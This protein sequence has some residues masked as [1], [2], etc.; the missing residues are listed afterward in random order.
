MASALRMR[1]TKRREVPDD[2]RQATRRRRCSRYFFRMATAGQDYRWGGEFGP[3][4]EALD[5]VRASGA[6]SATQG[7]ISREFA[8]ASRDDYQLVLRDCGALRG[9]A[10]LSDH[11]ELVAVVQAHWHASGSNGCRFAVYLSEHRE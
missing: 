3:F 9:D 1:A 4:R 11:P 5:S 10:S 7:G 8:V 2:R 6:Y